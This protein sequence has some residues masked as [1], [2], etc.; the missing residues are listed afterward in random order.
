[1]LKIRGGALEEIVQLEETEEEEAVENVQT[2]IKREENYCWC[3][4]AKGQGQCNLHE[5]DP[6]CSKL[7]YTSKLP[8]S[9]WL[10][11]GENV[12]ISEE[13][14]WI[15]DESFQGNVLMEDIRPLFESYGIKSSFYTFGFEIEK[16]VYERDLGF[17]LQQV[18][19]KLHLK[20]MIVQRRKSPILES[21][22]NNVSLVDWETQILGKMINN[23][24]Q[25]KTCRW[26]CKILQ[27]ISAM[28]CDFDRRRYAGIYI[29]VKDKISDNKFQKVMTYL[30]VGE[31]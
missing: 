11:L 27:D 18:I 14:R 2:Y 10:K 31:F 12:Y 3:V 5:S 28:L 4:K 25:I 9:L 26:K 8:F 30:L 29:L 17:C 24:Y 22:N 16:E 7:P 23:H 1:M 21:L 19:F 6:G 20:K 15:Q 13:S